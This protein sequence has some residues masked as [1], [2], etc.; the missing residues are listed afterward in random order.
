M[1][2]KNLMLYD[3]ERLRMKLYQD[4]L[5]AI[6]RVLTED[7]DGLSGS[8]ETIKADLSDI[9]E[10]HTLPKTLKDIK[11]MPDFNPIV[12]NG[13]DSVSGGLIKLTKQGPTC[14]KHGAM[15]CVALLKAGKLYR[16]L[17]CNEG[18]WLV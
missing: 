13:I 9:K 14:N 1:R 17:A 15:N 3:T 4:Q 16:C 10:A 7:V 12:K 5:T 11:E 6:L 18:G 2:G 8:I